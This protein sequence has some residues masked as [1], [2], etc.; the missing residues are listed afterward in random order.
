MKFKDYL[1]ERPNIE[2]AK[3]SIEYLKKR[4]IEAKDLKTQIEC[5]NEFNALRNHLDSMFSLASI[6]H[7]ID[8]KDTFYEQEQEFCDE[9]SPV[10]TNLVTEFFKEMVKSPFRPQLEKK[11]GAYFFQKIEVSLKAFDPIIMEDLVEENKLSTKYSKILASCSVEFQGKTCNLSQ[12]SAYFE[13]PKDEI[14]KEAQKQYWNFFQTHEQEID[15]IYDEMVHVRNRMAKKM[16]Y[17]NYV[18]LAY[19]QLGRTDYDAKMVEGYRKQILENIVPLHQKLLERQ[20]KRLKKDKLYYDDLPLS[21]LSGNA[22]P[23]GDRNHLVQSA[24]EM[25]SEMSMDTKEFFEYMLDHELLDLEAKPGKEGGGYC[26]YL[27]DFKSPFIFSNFN[28]TSGDVD[29]LTHE[30]GHAFQVYQSKEITI[31]EYLW[32][33]YEACEIHSMSMEFFAWPW[34]DKFFKQ[35]APKYRFSHLESAISFL[36]YGVSIDEF[37]HYVYE[38]P[39]ATSEMRKQK[40]REIEKKYLPHKDYKDNTLLEKGA[41]WFRQSHVFTSP[42]YYIDYTLAQVCAL[43]YLI[44]NLKSPKETWENY[45]EL[46][47][48]GGSKSFLDLVKAVGLENPFKEGTV[49][50]IASECEKILDGM[51]DMSM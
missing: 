37:Q 14:R 1:Y 30:A 5:I 42:F 43:Q 36:P 4:F 2:E 26:T 45:V 8:T 50:K 46:C 35:D 12:L 7:S 49:K 44:R 47:K 39:E 31:P 34:M 41:Y 13:N 3:E 9:N 33:T 48:L 51:D 22:T 20:R 15:R 11:Y 28:G 16:G 23:K 29:V 17:K 40:Y 6:R 21:F 38:H 32:P 27:P 25:Y 18:E 10:Y 24:F 19:L